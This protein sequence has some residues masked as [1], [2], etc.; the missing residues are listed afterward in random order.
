MPASSMDGVRKWK[1]T[2]TGLSAVGL[3][4]TDFWVNPSGELGGS[5]GLQLNP[6]LSLNDIWEH[7]DFTV[8]QGRARRKYMEARIATLRDMLGKQGTLVIDEGYTEAV[9]YTGITCLGFSPAQVTNDIFE[10]SLDFGYPQANTGAGSGGIMLAHRLEF[11]GGADADTLFIDSK[12]MVLELTDSGD[13]TDFKEVFRAAP[14]RVQGALPL[15]FLNVLGVVDRNITSF[16]SVTADSQATGFYVNRLLNPVGSGYFK[17]GSGALPRTVTAYRGTFGLFPPARYGVKPQTTTKA[18]KTWT[19]HG[20]D[21]GT[22]WTL[23][24]TQTG[25]TGWVSGTEKTF[26]ITSANWKYFKLTVTVLDGGGNE[27]ELKE[28]NLYPYSTSVSDDYHSAN[29]SQRFK[30]EDRFRSIRWGQCGRQRELRIN[31]S[32]LLGTTELTAHLLDVQI[33]D[34]EGLDTPAFRLAFAYGY[35]TPGT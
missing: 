25:I 35:G 34:I 26:D 2:P 33:D 6:K 9:T 11:G 32:A 27:M 29:H 12:N 23:V 10:Y 8:T 3:N 17:S 15:K 4:G 5:D 31:G 16:W 19:L 18:P 20:S 22:T 21:D 30:I 7:A 13:R 28:F 24:D 14:I 1:F